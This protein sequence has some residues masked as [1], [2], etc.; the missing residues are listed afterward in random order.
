MLPYEDGRRL[1]V[2]LINASTVLLLEFKM[3]ANYQQA[4]QYQVVAYVN[5]VQ[6]IDKNGSCYFA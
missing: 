1:D 2:L 6:T 4:Y 3:A 5:I